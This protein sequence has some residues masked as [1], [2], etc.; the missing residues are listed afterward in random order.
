MCRT[1]TPALPALLSALCLTACA[2]P[3]PVRVVETVRLDV[4]PA[5]LTC[6]A[7]P[8]PPAA[9][10]SDRELARWIARVIVA[11]QDC[12]GKLAAVARIARP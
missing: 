5:L 9:G 8:E 3:E 2:A 10:A 11:G 12:R 1:P 6:M 7:Q 4:P